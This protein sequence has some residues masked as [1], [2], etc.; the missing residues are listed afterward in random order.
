MQFETNVAP[1]ALIVSDNE[2]EVFINIHVTWDGVKIAEA[3][4]CADEDTYIETYQR[5][6]KRQSK[7]NRDLDKWIN[8]R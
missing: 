2:A 1:K 6:D 5:L 8:T 3:L 7:Q 4:N